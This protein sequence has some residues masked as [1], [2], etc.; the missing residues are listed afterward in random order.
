M[1]ALD[2]FDGIQWGRSSDR[3]GAYQAGRPVGEPDHLYQ[4]TTIDI[5]QRVVIEGLGGILVPTAGLVNEVHEINPEGAINPNDFSVTSGA[6]IV[7]TPG[8][9][10]GDQYQLSAQ[11]SL[12]TEDLGALATDDTG[13]L[14]PIFAG[15]AAAGKFNGEPATAPESALSPDD[16]EFFTELPDNTPATIRGIALQRTSGAVTDFEKAWMLQAWFRDSGDFTYS[17]DVTTGNSALVLENWLAD[18]TSLNYRIGY[19]E[20]FAASMGVL[21]RALGIPTR[22]VWGF[23]PGEVVEENVNGETIE[24]IEVKDLNA[25]AWVEM[26]MEGFGWV[27]FDPTPRGG[28]YQPESLTASF[29]PTDFLPEEDAATVR[30]NSNLLVPVDPGSEPFVDQAPTEFSVPEQRWWFVAALGLVL[31]AGVTPFIKWQRRRRRIVRI[32][33][34]DITAA[35]DELVDRLSDLGSAVPPAMTPVEFARSTDSTLVHLATN[36]SATIYGGYQSRGDESDLYAVDGFVENNYDGLKR[37]RAAF[38]PRSLFR[39]D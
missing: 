1:E 28:D 12:Y 35:W 21:G 18:P 30:S 33:E 22:V 16:L 20:Q 5:L 24:V 8:L 38:N 39:R 25:H 27:Q 14:S 2:E 32:K 36:Y 15:A 9:S 19:C 37:T 4:G 10:A 26:W 23:T 17:L 7:Y 3:L 11:Y 34:G 6:A 29:D 31:L 13:N